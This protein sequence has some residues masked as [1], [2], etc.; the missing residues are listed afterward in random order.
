MIRV[1]P[2]STIK[3]ERPLEMHTNN[4]QCHLYVASLRFWIVEIFY[5]HKCWE[6]GAGGTG[7]SR[8]YNTEQ[9]W[10]QWNKLIYL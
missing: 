5:H 10:D 9:R 3:M 8:T 6:N 7:V 1:K 2:S 4:Q